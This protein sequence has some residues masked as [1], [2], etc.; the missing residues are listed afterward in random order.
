MTASRPGIAV[1]ATGCTSSVRRA[2][3]RK[4]I[5]FRSVNRPDGPGHDPGLQRHH[6]LP[7]ELLSQR[8]FGPMFETLGTDVIGFEDFRRNGM[9]LPAQERAAIRTALPLHR[10]P[11]R[12]YNQMV[13]ERVGQIEQ[14]WSMR[15]AHDPDGALREVWMRLALLQS[16]LRRRL[17]SDKRRLTLNRFDPL[18][19]GRDYS[20]LD[21][22]ADMLWATTDTV[23]S[24]Q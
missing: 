8:C 3:E 21:A 12:N 20:R 5:P 4:V 23:F 1:S 14:G 2:E 15:R 17:L 22:M 18:G 9:L 24:P 7:S 11:H 6:L 16:A 13:A 19:A 10:G